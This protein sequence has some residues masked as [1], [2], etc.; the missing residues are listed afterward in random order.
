MLIQELSA[1]AIETLVDLSSAM[2]TKAKEE[3]SSNSHHQDLLNEAEIEWSNRFSRYLVVF[4]NSETNFTHW[5]IKFREAVE[6]SSSIPERDCESI[7]DIPYRATE[8]AQR[9]VR[10]ISWCET[11]SVTLPELFPER[12]LNIS[13]IGF[14]M[15][16]IFWLETA[17]KHSELN[18]MMDSSDDP[19]KDSFPIAKIDR[20]IDHNYTVASL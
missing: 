9:V 18:A 5:F 16:A 2:D 15:A 14:Q 20:L 3:F 19:I 6:S 10:N 17:K 13:A 11:F 8:L 1:K 4:G 12:A 7:H